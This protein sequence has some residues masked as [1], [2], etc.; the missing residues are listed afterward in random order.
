MPPAQTNHI[1]PQ[2]GS[3]PTSDLSLLVS[4]HLVRRP[5]RPPAR[6]PLFLAEQPP[7][8]RRM[9]GHRHRRRQSPF[10]CP[11]TSA[12]SDGLSAHP[13]SFQRLCPTSRA[14]LPGLSQHYRPASSSAVT[15]PQAARLSDLFPALLP[16]AFVRRWLELPLQDHLPKMRCLWPHHSHPARWTSTRRC[17][18][19][20]FPPGYC[21]KAQVPIVARGSQI[22]PAALPT[23]HRPFVDSSLHKSYCPQRCWRALQELHRCPALNYD[24]LRQVARSFF[25]F[26]M[27]E[28]ASSW[29]CATACSVVIF[30]AEVY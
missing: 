5:A 19:A 1:L 8:H 24:E 12:P 18:G 23:Y 11:S 22:S 15:R 6:L 13:T 9:A 29:V 26:E 25:Y 7:L 27:H 20:S 3:S 16:Q 2:T 17:P 4:T 28:A 10:R 30:W 21:R 14:R